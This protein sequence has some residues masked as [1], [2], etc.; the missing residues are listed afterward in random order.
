MDYSNYYHMNGNELPRGNEK[1]EIMS[2]IIR[3]ISEK[4]NNIK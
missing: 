3:N 1:N 2:E 4:L